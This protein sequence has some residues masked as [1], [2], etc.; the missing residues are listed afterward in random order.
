MG[1]NA[2]SKLKND[3]QSSFRSTYFSIRSCGYWV[4]RD[5]VIMVH[6]RRD[7]PTRFLRFAKKI[8]IK[9]SFARG[10]K[11]LLT[12]QQ[13]TSTTFLLQYHGHVISG[14]SL[15]RS[16]LLVRICKPYSW[17][18][19]ASLESFLASFKSTL[20]S[21]KCNSLLCDLYVHQFPYRQ[22]WSFKCK[23]VRLSWILNLKIY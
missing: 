18:S 10:C 20:I 11:S 13:H 12:S 14:C 5:S 7:F 23:C 15:V 8:D 3:W 17:R 6:A 4:I 19:H 16:V 22:L 9:A 1:T 2:I 21:E